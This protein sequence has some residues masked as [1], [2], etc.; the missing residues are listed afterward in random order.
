MCPVTSFW[1][2]GTEG[3]P[4]GSG[5]AAMCSVAFSMASSIVFKSMILLKI[6]LAESDRQGREKTAPPWESRRTV[7]SPVQRWRLSSS[8]SVGL[9]FCPQSLPDF[10]P[11]LGFRW[12]PRG[13]RQRLQ[14][15]PPHP[16]SLLQPHT[17]R[18]IGRFVRMLPGIQVSSS[19]STCRLPDSAVDDRLWQLSRQRTLPHLHLHYC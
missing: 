5:W 3:T 16:S 11:R 6:R 2:S 7:R 17:M 14:G 4:A 13:H 18:D 19:P 8:T 1:S 9:E 12:F 10:V 15:G